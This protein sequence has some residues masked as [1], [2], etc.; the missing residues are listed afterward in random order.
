[1][2][3][4]V[5]AYGVVVFALLV[6]VVVVVMKRARLAREAELLA[7]LQE[8]AAGDAGADAPAPSAPETAA[9]S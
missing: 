5:S 8:R 7:L 3:Y 1:M 4:V 6:Y 2:S 9:R